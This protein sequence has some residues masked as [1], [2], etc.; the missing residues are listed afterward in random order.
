MQ[1]FEAKPHRLLKWW[2]NWFEGY[3]G[4]AI[5]RRSIDESIRVDKIDKT[6][7]VFIIKTDNLD[8]FKKYTRILTPYLFHLLYRF[9]EGDFSS[10][11]TGNGC[12][13]SILCKSKSARYPTRFCTTIEASNSRNLRV[14]NSSDFDLMIWSYEF[15]NRIN[16]S[17]FIRVS[18]WRCLSFTRES[19]NR[20]CLRA[21][22]TAGSKHEERK[23]KD[24]I[25]KYVH[26]KGI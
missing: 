12:I 8:G 10:L 13:R 6:I 5:F 19:R 3:C 22:H 9:L 16:R 26:R 15:K 25:F 14:R 1:N 4:D 17:D 11:T 24:G 7:G 18:R 2:N 21:P 23:K 20:R